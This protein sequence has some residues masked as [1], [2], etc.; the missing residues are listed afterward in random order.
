MLPEE[1][2]ET[3]RATNG[4]CLDPGGADYTVARIPL[5]FRLL[6]RVEDSINGGLVRT[7]APRPRVGEYWLPGH[8]DRTKPRWVRTPDTGIAVAVRVITEGRMRI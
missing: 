3:I 8:W 2:V 4:E 1:F 5:R 7:V 6:A